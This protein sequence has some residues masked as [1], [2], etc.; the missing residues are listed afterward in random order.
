M[1]VHEIPVCWKWTLKPSPHLV[2]TT[3][4]FIWFKNAKSEITTTD[5]VY[6]F[7]ENG[8]TFNAHVKECGFKGEAD[9]DLMQREDLKV[10]KDAFEM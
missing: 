7:L 5:G 8:V 6:S 2:E 1:T 4:M 3:D 10:L 9:S